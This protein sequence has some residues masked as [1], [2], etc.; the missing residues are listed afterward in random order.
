MSKVKKTDLLKLKFLSKIDLSPSKEYLSLVVSK[1]KEDQKGY[2]SD[3][4]IYSIKEDRWKQYT[5]TGK[6]KSCF[7][8][9][10][11][12]KL[13]LVGVRTKEE[14]EER[15]KGLGYTVL[16]ELDMKG[17]EA[18]SKY[19]IPKDVGKIRQIAKEQFLFT[20]SA[21]IGQKEPFRMDEEE[22]KQVIQSMEENKDYEEIEKIPYWSNGQGFCHNE[23]TKLYLYDG[24][25]DKITVL[26]DHLKENITI[27]DFEVGKDNK[28]VVLYQEQLSKMPLVNGLMVADIQREKVL[29]DD[30]AKTYSYA[31]AFLSGKEEVMILASDMKHH[32]LNENS[33][34]YLLNYRTG[35]IH[36]PNPQMDISFWN[37]VGS[38]VRLYG[39]ESITM[40]EDKIYFLG[41]KGYHQV[42]Q[43]V[44]LDGTIQEILRVEGSVDGYALGKEEVYSICLRDML[45][46]EVYLDG[47]EGQKISSFNEAFT[48]KKSTAIPK[49]FVYCPEKD[50]EIDYW[51]LL[52]AKAKENKKYPVILDIHG[53]PKTA[54]G[55]VYFH[56]MQYFCSEGF[57]V[58]YCNPR[59]SDGKGN[60]FADIRGQYGQVDYQDIMGVLEEALSSQEM[61]D[62][63]NVFVTGGSYG[64]FMTNWIVGQTNRFRG[65]ATQRSI[66]NWISMFGTTDIGYFFAEDQT[67]ANPWNQMDKM[68][69]QSPLKYADKVKTPTLIIHSDEDYRC[70]IA[71]G[72]QMFTALQYHG[73]ESKM[74]VFRGENHE[75][76]R[77]GRPD[78][79]IK[80]L[81]EL[82]DWFKKHMK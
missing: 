67:D 43:S 3:I 40:K 42:L 34:Y 41:T 74:V 55:E 48:E 13:Y 61:L 78:H 54:Y 82:V 6:D 23:V 62:S 39:S 25:K 11:E 52:P 4:Y 21:K 29:F 36:C 35:E 58:V 44:G 76:S 28:V 10:K 22:K 51:I 20:A 77:S 8:D 73:V 70:W 59:G 81:T 19:K 26:S 63:E 15:K 32:G 80:R 30:G 66:S 5:Q 56:E 7:W 9:E 17:G 53:G 60:H 71:E 57:A 69:N 64:G 37:S 75:L 31:K 38:D 14:E 33:K 2:E 65:A 72:Y 12:D 18:T 27:E 1:A 79:R 47:K 45:P 16:R 46:Q 50:V 49:H 24:V 68:W